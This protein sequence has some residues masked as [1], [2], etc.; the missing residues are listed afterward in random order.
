MKNTLLTFGLLLG[1]FHAQQPAPQNQTDYLLYKDDKE[2]VLN[3]TYQTYQELENVPI[4]IYMYPKTEDE[5]TTYLHV[6]AEYKKSYDISDPSIVGSRTYD[7]LHKNNR[8]Y[9]FYEGNYMPL[10]ANKFAKSV[11]RT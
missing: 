8:L 2:L 4:K 6:I 5:L 3:K 1:L 11:L 10:I 9:H 7:Y